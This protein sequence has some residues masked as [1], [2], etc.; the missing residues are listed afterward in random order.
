[1]DIRTGP[2]V[3]KYK[4]MGSASV[5]VPKAQSTKFIPFE[6]GTDIRTGGF[7]QTRGI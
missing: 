4:T 7:S 5:S 6:L 3:I 1:M 2:G